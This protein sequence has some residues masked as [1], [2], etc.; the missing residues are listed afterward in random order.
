MS[1]HI[2]TLS[3]FFLN[4]QIRDSISPGKEG[5]TSL[6]ELPRRGGG[7]TEELEG[8]SMEV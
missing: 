1:V 5:N 7:V 8:L 6:S 3:L 2:P 4:E